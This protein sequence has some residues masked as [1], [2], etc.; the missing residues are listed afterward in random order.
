MRQAAATDIPKPYPE[1]ANESLLISMRILVS[2]NVT[3]QS[4]AGRNRF[5]QLA[6]GTLGSLEY[7]LALV[8]TWS[9]KYL[10]H[11]CR[12]ILDSYLIFGNSLTSI[13][14]TIRSEPC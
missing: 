9:L 6:L 4:E 7:V 2:F 8:R 5:V 3:C 11:V 12:D 14:E 10:I 13:A 1:H